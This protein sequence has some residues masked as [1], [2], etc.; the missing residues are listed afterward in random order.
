MGDGDNE[1]EV[2][3]MVN[4]GKEGVGRITREMGGDQRYRDGSAD[5][6]GSLFS[7]RAARRCCW[8]L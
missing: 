8:P 2:E 4:E 3:R 6:E 7:L 5:L 1:D